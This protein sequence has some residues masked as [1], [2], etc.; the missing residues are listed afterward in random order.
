MSKNYS[1]LIRNAKQWKNGILYICFL[2]FDEDILQK[3]KTA[4]Y[5]VLCMAQVDIQNS[6]NSIKKALFTMLRII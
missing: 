1:L 2:K 6:V 3:V 5:K 4:F